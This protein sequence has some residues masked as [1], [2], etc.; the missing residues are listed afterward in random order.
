MTS[1]AGNT[2][3]ATKHITIE[4]LKLLIFGVLGRDEE[5]LYYNGHICLSTVADN[6]TN[7]EHYFYAILHCRIL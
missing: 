7:N 1:I 3:D 6:A 2:T 5:K 4:F